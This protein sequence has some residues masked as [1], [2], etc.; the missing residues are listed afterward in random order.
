MQTA[1][2]QKWHGRWQQL[3]GRVKSIWG[4]IIDDEVT[5]TEG[6]YENLIGKL[7]AK[8]GKTREDLEKML[9]E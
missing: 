2:E 9:N 7:Q 6:D 1:S 4:N 5:K 3:V 8:T